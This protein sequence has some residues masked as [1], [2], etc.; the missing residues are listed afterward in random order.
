MM[1]RAIIVRQ[2]A[3]AGALAAVTLGCSEPEHYRQSLD[4]RVLPPSLTVR[5]PPQRL[6]ESGVKPASAELPAEQAPV[7]PAPTESPPVT[8]GRAPAGPISL[9]EAVELA[10]RNQP[11]LRVFLEGIAQ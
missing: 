2:L 4:H 5:Q 8:D 6:P 9:P 3:L 10:Y 11:R 7:T 1:D